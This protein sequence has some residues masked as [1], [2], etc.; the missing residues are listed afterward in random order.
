MPLDWWGL[1]QSTIGKQYCRHQEGKWVSFFSFTYKNYHPASIWSL[2]SNPVSCPLNSFLN[3]HRAKQNPE[4]VLIASQ[5]WL[6]PGSGSGFIILI[7]V[8]RWGNQGSTKSQVEPPNGNLCESEN[9][10]RE[11][12]HTGRPGEKTRAVKWHQF[13]IWIDQIMLY[14]SHDGSIPLENYVIYIY[15]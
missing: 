3:P 2:G 12:H 9:F 15:I 13:P 1:L 6:L 14:I 7:L 8:I 4:L 10:R 5:L 11:L